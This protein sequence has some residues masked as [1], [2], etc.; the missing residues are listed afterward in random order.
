MS[1]A[2]DERHQRS[3]RK[4][5]QE[6]LHLWEEKISSYPD[7]RQIPTQDIYDWC[8]QKIAARDDSIPLNSKQRLEALDLFEAYCQQNGVVIPDPDWI[9]AIRASLSRSKKPASRKRK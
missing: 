2:E 9:K 4:A 1:K 3:I 8:Q 5:L 6:N 7:P